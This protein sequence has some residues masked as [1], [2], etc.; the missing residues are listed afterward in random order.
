MMDFI[1]THFY[2]LSI[3]ASGDTSLVTLLWM[4]STMM[5]RHAV[6]PPRPGASLGR[7][8]SVVRHLC[9]FWLL[10]QYRRIDARVGRRASQASRVLREG[11]RSAQ[12]AAVRLE[13]A[14]C[15]RAPSSIVPRRSKP[16]TRR[17]IR[18]GLS[19]RLAREQRLPS[20]RIGSYFGIGAAGRRGP[21]AVRRAGH[22]HDCVP[23]R[24]HAGH[25]RPASSTACV[26]AKGYRNFETDDASTNLWPIGLFIAGEELHNNHHAFPT[27][28]R[29]SMRPHEV[30][31]GWLHLKVLAALGLAKIR[32]V[33]T[34]PSSSRERVRLR[35]STSCVRS[36]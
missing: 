34:P 6:L 26:T 19:E 13:E 1:Y 12:P 22:H 7:P 15:S 35:T 2:G 9:R 17:E 18:E 30:D 11:R 14:C 29:F 36:S 5:C 32:R 16:E 3:S 20:S 28:A 24:E 21:R 31:M 27:S 10:A 25:S 33:A 8:A 4:H 23:A